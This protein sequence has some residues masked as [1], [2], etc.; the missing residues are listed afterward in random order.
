MAYILNNGKVQESARIIYHS[1]E[2]RI[3]HTLMIHELTKINTHGLKI[4]FIVSLARNTAEAAMT[5]G[6]NCTQLYSNKLNSA[7]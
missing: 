7:R 5:E 2:V 3:K 6:R 1:L 4:G